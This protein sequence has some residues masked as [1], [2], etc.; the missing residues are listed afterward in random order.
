MAS[1][2]SREE[3]RLRRKQRVRK[4]VQGTEDRPRLCV[5]RS[6]KYTYAQLIVDGAGHVLGSLSTQKVKADGSS[7]RS[8]ESAR[9][10]GRKIAEVAQQKNINQV[11]FDRNG[12]LYH[13]RI[14]AVAD[15]AREGGLNF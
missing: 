11:V 6:H 9:E 1:R 2:S 10:L 14:A 8:V 7:S 15:G 5:Y 13:G 4:R 3:S 12:Y